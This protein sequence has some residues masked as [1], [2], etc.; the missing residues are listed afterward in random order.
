MA[1]ADFKVGKG[2]IAQNNSTFTTG[3]FSGQITS[4]VSTGTAPFVI[5]STTEVANLRAAVSTNIFGGGTG[6]VVYQSSANTSAFLTLGTQNYF[7]VAGASAPTYVQ[8]TL[9]TTYF[10]ATTSS[11]LRGVISDPTGTAG[12]LVWSTSPTFSTSVITDSA[13]FDVFNT[14][15]TTVNAFGA[16]TTLALG[17][18]SG[19]A[20]IGNAT[21]TLSNATTLNVNGASPTL[22]S[23][24]TGTLT[25]FNTNLLTVNAFGAA[26]TATLLGSATTLTIGGASGAQTITI[27]GASTAASTYNFGTGVTA[28]ATTK[29]IN[30]GTGGAA[31][32]VTNINIGSASATANSSTTT[33]NTKLIVKGDLQVDGT[34]TT[35]NSTTI[36]VDDPMI[37][38]GGDTVPTSDDNLDRG[39]EFRW[40]NGTAAKLGFFGYDDST[41]YFAF[42]PDATDTAGVISGT[43]GTFDGNLTGTAG[44]ATNVTGGSAGAI[45][46]QSASGTTAKNLTIGA[47]NY[48]L[49]SDGSIPVWTAN[50]GTGSV[51]RAT[52][53]SLTTPSLGAAT[54]T[55]INSLALTSLSTG[56]KI[57]GGTTAVEVS[58]LG[59]AAY[60]LSG[61]NTAAYTLPSA[62]ATLAAN[63]QTFYI[64]TTQVAINRGTGA[65]SLNGVSI[66]GSSGSVANSHVLK[67]DTGTTEGT[68]LYTY[69][70]SAAKTVDIKAGTNITLTKTAGSV[71]IASNPTSL[72]SV[73][74]DTNVLLDSNSLGS[75][76]STSAQTIHSFAGNTYR[77]AKLLVQ[78]TQGT[79]YRVSEVIVMH[80]SVSPFTTASN[81][82]VAEYGI[83]E[84]GG[85]I[86]VTIDASYSSGT[87]SITATV[88]DASTT[89]Y[90][91]K[92]FEI[93]MIL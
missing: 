81:V 19:T 14:T 83:V 82:S 25:L 68:D 2:F 6:T 93:A 13:S 38:L 72:P 58:F 57:S 61:T 16:A 77:S 53:P 46:Y 74:V 20:T 60:S 70:G 29:T 73:T 33:L 91:V 49:T 52:S 4:T 36:T 3:S 48:V 23:S 66:D 34:T 54:A 86:P 31:G 41:G 85:T 80:D 10:A 71:T 22:A 1:T 9:S 21:V 51:V 17:A 12:K 84:L 65:L 35:V 47:N 62:S 55:T 87:C 50:T 42:V 8:P 11:A 76:S 40:H 43:V 56:W 88:T 79:K 30:I 89:A 64:G 26:T 27:G 7:L 69:N 15:A 32:S 63:N 5:A 90:T 28:N 75:T 67:F 45:L 24:S 44:S 37:V 18:S 92:A 78:I 59:G 39:V